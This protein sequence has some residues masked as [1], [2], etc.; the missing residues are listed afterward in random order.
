MD[1]LYRMLHIAWRV[2]P[3]NPPSIGKHAHAHDPC[4]LV[5]PN[6]NELS[7]TL[8]ESGVCDID[9]AMS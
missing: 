1:Q 5:V 9:A 3:F 4:N 8:N 2:V 6:L 7:L